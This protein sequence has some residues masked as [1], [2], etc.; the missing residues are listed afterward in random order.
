M[1]GKEGVSCEL[2]ENVRRKSEDEGT[3]MKVL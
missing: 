3:E 2:D 1:D